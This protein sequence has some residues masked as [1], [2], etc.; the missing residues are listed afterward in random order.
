[1]GAEAFGEDEAGEAGADDEVV[2]GHRGY[3]RAR[4]ND[5]MM[6]DRFMGKAEMLKE[7]RSGGADGLDRSRGAGGGLV[8]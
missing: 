8:K 6:G 5:R 1:L 4:S 3:R 2:V 7:E